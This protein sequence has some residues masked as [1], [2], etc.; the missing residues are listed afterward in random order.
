MT[1]KQY[2]IDDV[3]KMSIS[4]INDKLNEQSTQIALLKSDIDDFKIELEFVKNQRDKLQERNYDQRTRLK[5]LH[6]LLETRDLDKINRYLKKLEV[7]KKIWNKNGNV[8][9]GDLE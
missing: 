1:E 4:E 2:T 6:E 9:P 5:E 8:R 3:F 7:M